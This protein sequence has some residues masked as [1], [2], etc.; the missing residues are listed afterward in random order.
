MNYLASWRR[1][2]AMVG[3]LTTSQAAE[4][5]RVSRPTIELWY[6]QVKFPNAEPA[7]TPRG[8]ALMIP[9]NDLESFVQPKAGRPPKA[10]S[11]RAEAGPGAC[12]AGSPDGRT[13]GAKEGGDER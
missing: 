5:L 2:G 10:K 9:E 3:R 1:Y 12:G 13:V 7:E 4:R 8:P 11:E 6:R